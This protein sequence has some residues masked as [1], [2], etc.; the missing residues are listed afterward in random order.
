MSTTSD[1]NTAIAVAAALAGNIPY[2][3]RGGWS[4]DQFATDG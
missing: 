2:V 3:V 1:E 4:Y